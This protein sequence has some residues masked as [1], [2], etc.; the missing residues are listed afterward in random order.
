[1]DTL[2]LDRFKEVKKILGLRSTEIVAQTGYSKQYISNVLTGRNPI[3]DKFIDYFCFKFPV[4]NADYINYG[5][6]SILLNEQSTV[7]KH[8]VNHSTSNDV[9]ILKAE[10]KKVSLELQKANSEIAW[11]KGLIEKAFQLQPEL[12][13]KLSEFIAP[14]MVVLPNTTQWTPQGAVA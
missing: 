10:L 6:G 8:V 11:L 14:G 7:V 4:V 3:T 5:T 1:M 2:K 12:R 9:S 13:S